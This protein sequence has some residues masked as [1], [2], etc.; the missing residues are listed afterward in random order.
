MSG[1]GAA[2]RPTPPGP[3]RLPAHTVGRVLAVG[4]LLLIALLTLYP[5]PGQKYASAATPVFCLVCGQEGGQDVVLNLLLFTPFGVGLRLMGLPWSRVA[6][7][8]GLVSLS[9]ESLQYFVIP[10]RDASL[11]D[12]LTNTT[13]GALGAAVAPFLRRSIDPTHRSPRLPYLGAC[14]WLGVQG[15]SAWLLSPWLP[16]G[17][18]RSGWA[19]RAADRRPFHGQV[20]RV[21][22]Q[23]VPM[24]ADA[25]VPNGVEIR[26]ALEDGEV[27]LELEGTSGVPSEDRSAVYKIKAGT[28]PVLTLYER[29]RDFF[30]AV[31]ARALQLRL[32]PP[33]VKL[34][35]GI[36]AEATKAFRVS[37][38]ERDRRIWIRASSGE[39]ERLLKVTLSPSLGWSLV[40][41]FGLALGPGFRLLTA[42]W[43]VAF[44][45]PLGFWTARAGKP[46]LGRLTLAA[47][48][49]LGLG[50]VPALGG[51]PPVHWSEWLGAGLGCGAGWALYRLA[52]YL[53]TRCGSPSSNAFSSS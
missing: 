44:M 7:V 2:L 11:S 48:L 18:M 30:F 9:V 25:P 17:E 5:L 42:M 50:V 43:L 27:S 47:T 21:Q 6:L 31:P 39:T 32:V 1:G 19:H 22:L 3:R 20:N 34:P 36:P 53:Q 12:L 28:T 23:G 14:A 51:Y 13:G 41:A 4:G 15:L 52:S 8:C 26:A 40:A 49:G 24:P 29:S 33:T 35:A 16:S 46:W 45:V 37:A 10:G 38:G